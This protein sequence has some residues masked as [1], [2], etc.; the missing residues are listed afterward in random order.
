MG[1]NP[2]LPSPAQLLTPSAPVSGSA[3]ALWSTMRGEFWSVTVGSR[4]NSL[5]DSWLG[6]GEV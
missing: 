6:F 4:I 3:M 2:H 1:L 5:H